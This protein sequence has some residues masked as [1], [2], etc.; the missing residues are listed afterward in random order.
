MPHAQAEEH[1]Q[2]G[3]GEVLQ[4]EPRVQGAGDWQEG[5]DHQEVECEY[6]GGREEAQEDA[7]ETQAA[8]GHEDQGLAEEGRRVGGTDRRDER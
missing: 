5:R 8:G 2:E 7:V 1:E 3:E 4:G 6:R